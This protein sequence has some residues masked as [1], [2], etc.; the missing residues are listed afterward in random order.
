MD[1]VQT[2]VRARVDV[3]RATDVVAKL[4]EGFGR[5]V[6]GQ[7]SL[8]RNLIIALIAEGHVLL[9]S[10]P[11]L[12]KTTAVRTLAATVGLDFGR[13]QCTPDLLPSDITGTEIYNQA[14]NSFDTKLGPVHTNFLLLDEINRSSAK[15]QSAMLEAMQ[16]G[17]TTIGGVVHRLPEPFLVV[18]TQNPI[19]QEGTYVLPEAQLDRFLLKEIVRYPDSADEFEMLRR[20][21]DGEL[22]APSAPVLTRDDVLFL[23]GAARA[24]HVDDT[25][26]RYALTIVSATRGA[27]SYL[28]D[29]ARYVAAGASPRAG[30][31][32]VS[33]A[34]ALALMDGR[35][36]VLPEDVKALAHPILRHRLSLTFDAELDGV[37]VEDVIDVVVAAVQTP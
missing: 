6:I 25:V 12:A 1:V 35:D 27:T 31:A 13:V 8:R 10:L 21:R 22:A 19:E 3:G 33:A 5:G 29:Q 37:S 18:A 32:F 28:G 20:I 34:R 11:G 4:E 24:V 15:T 17:Q 16:E 9:E 2:R 7:E 30:I 36:H 23:Q 26:L 14:Q